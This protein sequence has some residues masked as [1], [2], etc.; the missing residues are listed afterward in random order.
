MINLPSSYSYVGKIV[1]LRMCI[2]LHVQYVV[3]QKYYYAASYFGIQECCLS[4]LQCTIKSFSGQAPSGTTE[5]SPS[6]TSFP[7][8]A[9][10]CKVRSCHRMS[11][12]RPSVCDVMDC[13]D[14]GWNSSKMILRLVSLVCSLSADPNVTGLLQ[15]EYPEIFA[16]IGVGVE[17]SDFWRKKALISLKRGKIGPRFRY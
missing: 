5:R 6:Q 8:D 16:R 13:D 14:I 2:V 9:L 15:G 11:S 7:R 3:R 12:V 10:Q 17:K 4:D 1:T